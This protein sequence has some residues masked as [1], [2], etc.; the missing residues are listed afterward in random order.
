MKSYNESHKGRGKDYDLHYKKDK[1]DAW[2]WSIEQKI[3]DNFINKEQNSKIENYL[4]FACGTGRII[5]KIE[6][7]AS[8][9]VGIDISETMIKEAKKRCINSNLIVHNIMESDFDTK[10]YDLITAFRFFKN[11]EDKLRRNAFKTI[12]KKLLTEGILIFNNHGNRWTFQRIFRFL[13]G[14]KIDELDFKFPE[15]Y[16]PHSYLKKLLKQNGLEIVKTEGVG[17]YSGKFNN[18]SYSFFRLFERF[19]PFKLFCSEIIYFVKKNE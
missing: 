10:K 12:N 5:E 2:I 13:M 3:L 8:N 11:A 16:P 17:I 9:S 4:D 14:K 15:R 7:Y 19:W 6:R 1:R 18:L